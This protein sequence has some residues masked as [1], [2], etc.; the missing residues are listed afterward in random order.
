[1]LRGHGSLKAL[2]G[3]SVITN[4]GKRQRKFEEQ[5]E[6]GVIQFGLNSCTL[7]LLD[8]ASKLR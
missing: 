2:L 5:D 8:R 7:I 3:R 4:N 6:T 1:M